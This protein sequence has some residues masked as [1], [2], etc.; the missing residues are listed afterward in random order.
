L[1]LK[2]LPPLKYKI[3]DDLFGNTTVIEKPKPLRSYIRKSTGKIKNEYF[4][5]VTSKKGFKTGHE[6]SKSFQSIADAMATQ[7]GDFLKNK[8][9]LTKSFYS[10]MYP[11]S[12]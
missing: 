3:N 7:W 12:L 10:Q 6:R 11:P 2:N 8:N 5:T 9:R 1:W 4:T